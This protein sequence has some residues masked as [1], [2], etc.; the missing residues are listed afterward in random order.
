MKQL[1]HRVLF[2]LCLP[3]TAT[4][5]TPTLAS[6]TQLTIAF[7][8][9]GVLLE[10]NEQTFAQELGEADLATY[11]QQTGK[12]RVQLWHL[13][14]KVLKRMGYDNEATAGASDPAGNRTPGLACAWMLG[15]RSCREL[16]QLI[17]PVIEEH[18]EWFCSN[19]EQTLFYR[20]VNLLF[21]PAWFARIQE[22]QPGAYQ[23]VRWCKK[24]GHRV[25][26]LS[27]WCRES[28]GCML[29]QHR[30]FFDLFDEV[31]VSGRVGMMKPDP[32]IFHYL[33]RYVPAASCIFIDNQQEN[34]DAARKLGIHAIFCPAYGAFP[35]LATVAK[36]L[37]ELEASLMQQTGDTKVAAV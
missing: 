36:E 29:E 5:V 28:F 35:D 19:L 18:P 9:G 22:L 27:N 33:T 11:H 13:L 6:H 21:T 25:V 20:F 17:N 23:L 37:R 26:V 14:Y 15:T 16:Q 1:A 10:T 8:L 4:A 31:I 32:K 24:R 7:D 3:L 30:V 2:A 34:I 12:G